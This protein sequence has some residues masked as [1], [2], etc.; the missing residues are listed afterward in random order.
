MTDGKKKHPISLALDWADLIFMGFGGIVSLAGLGSSHFPHADLIGL[1]L[2]LTGLLTFLFRIKTKLEMLEKVAALSVT[3]AESADLRLG[4]VES[5]LTRLNTLK[6]LL[7]Q[8]LEISDAVK[9]AKEENSPF[10]LRAV[11]DVID[12]IAVNYLPNSAASL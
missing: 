4:G 9:Q 12:N 1:G 7:V 3:A 10:Y 2:C 11:G 5:A 6:S 8:T